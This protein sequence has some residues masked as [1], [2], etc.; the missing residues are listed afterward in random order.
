VQEGPL[1]TPPHLT[2]LK[3]ESEG[4]AELIT[5]H[6]KVRREGLVGGLHEMLNA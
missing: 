2:F 6:P 5:Y 4:R 3:G 1:V